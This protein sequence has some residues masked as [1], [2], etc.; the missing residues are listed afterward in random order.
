MS[1]AMRLSTPLAAPL[2]LGEATANPLELGNAAGH[3]HLGAFLRQMKLG[4]EARD[5]FRL[6]G[7][8]EFAVGIRMNRFGGNCLK[9]IKGNQMPRPRERVRLE[10]GLKLDL[11]RLIHRT[12]CGRA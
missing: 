11:N 4:C 10:D 2:S 3:M 1:E 6:P 5:H 12:S 7:R 8:H 9:T